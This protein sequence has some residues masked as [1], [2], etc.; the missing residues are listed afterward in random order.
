MSADAFS[1]AAERQR[2]LRHRRKLGLLVA[3]AEVP[4]QLAERLVEAGL[5]PEDHSADPERLGAALVAACNEW[6]GK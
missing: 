1:P 2:R 6:A 4:L 3:A 5:L